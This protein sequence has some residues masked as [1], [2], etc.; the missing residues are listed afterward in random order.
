MGLNL[1]SKDYGLIGGLLAVSAAIGYLGTTGFW[2]GFVGGDVPPGMVLEMWLDRLTV[3]IIFAGLLAIYKARGLWGGEV[4]RNLELIGAGLA[5]YMLVYL[6]HIH[7]HIAESPAWLGMD[8]NFWFGF[9]HMIQAAAFFL[10]SYGFY[11][12]WQ[13]GKE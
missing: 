11:E 3:V 10:A 4:A 6:P 1:E 5:G 13:T 12:F 9:F 8:P 2:A 7:W